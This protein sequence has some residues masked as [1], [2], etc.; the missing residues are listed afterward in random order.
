M[1]K[2]LFEDNST[3]TAQ[4]ERTNPFRLSNTRWTLA[5]NRKPALKT[6]IQ[7]VEEN[8]TPSFKRVPDNLTRAERRALYSLHKRVG[9]VIKPADKGSATL[10]LSFDDYVKEAEHQLSNSDYYLLLKDDPTTTFTAEINNFLHQ[11]KEH[12]PI[13]SITQKFLHSSH[14]RPARFYLLPKIY[15]EGNP[16]RPIL[17][18]NNAPT[19]KISLFVDYHLRPLVEMIPSYIKDTTHFLHKLNS[20]STLSPNSLLVRVSNQ[21]SGAMYYRTPL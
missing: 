8:S 20:L 15:K 18:S 9:I 17:S 10:I 11:M 3:D 4:R 12:N 13:D 2:Y 21:I 1:C 16:G 19:E 6:Y 7:A 5:K 14:T